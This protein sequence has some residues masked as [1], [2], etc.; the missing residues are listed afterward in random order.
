[1]EFATGSYATTKVSMIRDA[2]DVVSKD[3]A[4]YINLQITLQ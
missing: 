4:I 3:Q 1:M 2:K